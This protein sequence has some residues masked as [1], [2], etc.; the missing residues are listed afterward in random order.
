M[1][2]HAQHHY[3]P[4]SG[5][6]YTCLQWDSLQLNALPLSHTLPPH[7]TLSCLQIQLPSQPIHLG[8]KSA[9]HADPTSPSPPKS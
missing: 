6:T 7:G 4:A 3:D 2:V 9:H 8:V 1:T 5:L